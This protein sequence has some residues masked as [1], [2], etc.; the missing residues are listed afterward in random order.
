MASRVVSIEGRRSVAQQAEAGARSSSRLVVMLLIPV[1][2][3]VIV[4]LGAILSASSV[5]ALRETGDSLYYF[6]RQLIWLGVGVVALAAASAIPIRWWRRLAFPFFALTV[7]LL[8]L[9]LAMGVRSYGATR[10]LV[11]GP[12]SVQPS[13]MAKLA[14]VLFLA[15]LVSRKEDSMHRLRDFLWP[16][17]LSV[18]VVSALTM[19]EPDLGTTL[20]IAAGA[21]AVLVASA[22]PA[23]YVFG[24]A[25]LGGTAALAAAATSPYRWQRVTTFLDVGSDPLGG[26]YQAVQSLVALVTGG[27]FGVGLGASRARWSFLPNAHNDFIFSIVGEE[28]GLAGSLAVVLLFVVLT[29]AG[30]VVAYRSADRFG[31]LVAVGITTWLVTQA[32]VNIGGVTGILPITGVPLPFVSFGG[33]A[34]VTEMIAIGVLIAVVRQ[35]GAGEPA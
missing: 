26:G 16:V 19:L 11:I 27:L 15:T 29:V 30:V 5:L 34:L 17:A 1:A 28:T 7:L 32:L 13:E 25:L 2:L 23:V 4:G 8:L 14:T 12:V 24:G 20:L 31:R 10:W 3:L 9:V 6:K 21:F 33:S 22:A 18:G 35:R